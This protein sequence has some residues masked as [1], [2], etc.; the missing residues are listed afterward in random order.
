M[1]A[2]HESLRLYGGSHA[3][4]GAESFLTRQGRNR[5]YVYWIALIGCA[6]GLIS[7]PLIRVD[8]TVQERGRVRPAAERGAIVARTSGFVASI[9]V[10]DN[11]PVHA[12]D[13]LLVLNTRDLE[14]RAD[15]NH[16]QTGLVEKE[17]ADL[18]HLLESAGTLNPVSVNDLQTPN[19]ASEYQRFDAEC[20]N[21]DLKIGRAEREMRRTKQLFDEKLAAAREFDQA[22]FEAKLSRTERELIAR[23]TLVKWQAD[24]VQ[25]GFELEQLRTQARQLAEEAKLYSVKAPVDGVVIGLEGVFEGSYVQSGQ[26]IGDISPTSDFVIDALV[27]P[28]D[29]GRISKGQAVN[30]QID[31]YPYTVWGLL[32]GRVI[33][34]SADYVQE[35]DATS[36]FKVIV[37][38]DRVY[39]E[40]LK[41]LQGSLKKGMTVTAR[42]FVARRSLWELLY[43]NLDTHFNPAMDAAS[44]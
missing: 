30:L 35:S 25:K 39:L 2:S 10:H 20:A 38:P 13:T 33:R 6:G 28:K 9:Q 40:A 12:G 34:I 1:N 18:S 11:D 37:R 5:P 21:A 19:Y 16:S 3:L 41:G 15:F 4:N 27:P 36:V 17:L 26:R 23:Q 22:I 43:E 44:S 29:I 32:P 24:K 7:L 8:V 42:F 14:A 31:A